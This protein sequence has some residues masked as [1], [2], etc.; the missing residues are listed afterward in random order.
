MGF[1]NVEIKARTNKDDKIRAFLLEHGAEFKGIDHQTD[2]YFNVQKGRL[3]LREGNIENNLIYYER[4]NENGPKNSHFNLIKVTDA[5]GLKEVLKKALGIKI[6]IRKKR[7]IYCIGNVKFHLDDVPELGKFVEIE[8]G[9]M[10]SDLEE[11]KLQEQCEFYTRE[12]E[13][14][15]T[16]LIAASYSDMPEKDMCR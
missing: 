8:A 12:F 16:D 2:T 7:E 4:V 14:E 13:I 10:L 6:I 5:S 3:K 9:N 15:P 1:L 11:R